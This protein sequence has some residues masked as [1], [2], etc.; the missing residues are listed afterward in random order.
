VVIVE[1][2]VDNDGWR[3]PKELH[4]C[5][6]KI[7]SCLGRQEGIEDKDLPPEVDQA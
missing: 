4:S 7:D 2:A 5:L 1:M 6:A 3:P